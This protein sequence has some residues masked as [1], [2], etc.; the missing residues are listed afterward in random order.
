MAIHAPQFFVDRANSVAATSF[1]A[2]DLL[3]MPIE[4][5]NEFTFQQRGAIF[6]QRFVGS[7]GSP[8]AHM[9]NHDHLLFMQHQINGLDD[10][11]FVVHFGAFPYAVRGSA[12]RRR[13]HIEEVFRNFG[14]DELFC[15]NADP[16]ACNGAYA[17]A[18]LP[19]TETSPMGTKIAF[20][21]P[22]GMYIRSFSAGDLF[23]GD[24]PVPRSWTLLERG[25]AN[26]MPQRLVFGP[27]DAEAVFLDDATIGKGP[28]A[29]S[30]NGYKLA[31]RIEVGPLV[32]VGA[33]EPIT[34]DMFN[35][36][37]GEIRVGDLSPFARGTIACGA[38]ETDVCQGIIALK[39]EFDK[40][41]SIA[42]GTRGGRIG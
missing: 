6:L 35:Q 28:G 41:N 32:V 40:E 22:L 27:S 8:P 37:I 5:W 2:L 1:R 14:R 21:D 11:V 24:E 26:G 38:A 12:G 23:L 16:N 10:L 18:F 33:P 3:G 36:S 4:Q 20:A 15:R 17:Q 7:S 29:K 9:I 39:R 19:G 25:A 30:V 13:A 34:P 31:K 42:L